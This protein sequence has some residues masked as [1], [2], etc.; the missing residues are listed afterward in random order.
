M[1]KIGLKFPVSS[2]VRW[3]TKPVL[4]IHPEWLKTCHSFISYIFT[5]SFSTTITNH[6]FKFQENYLDKT[7]STLAKLLWVYKLLT[8]LGGKPFCEEVFSWP[9]SVASPRSY[10]LPV[11]SL[12]V[13]LSE[14]K[15]REV[16]FFP[17]SAW[18]IMHTSS[19][20]LQ[21]N[22]NR[23]FVTS[24]ISSTWYPVL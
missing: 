13:W 14:M 7:H 10:W 8:F 20:C 5:Q 12:T 19:N 21:K 9:G 24:S 6:V 16:G 15:H 18:L 4:L 11:S 22:M 17:Q 23:T 1:T 3:R 2:S